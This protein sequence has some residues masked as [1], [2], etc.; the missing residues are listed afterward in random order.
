MNFFHGQAPVTSTYLFAAGLTL[1]SGLLFVS[2]HGIIRHIGGVG[3]TLHPLEIA[4]F[5]NL[6]SA[7]FYLPLFF[8]RG[9]Q[10]L[11]TERLPLHIVR[12][13]FNAT[14]ITAWYTALTLTPLA[15][16][17]ALGLSAPLFVTLGAF[18]FLGEIFRTRRWIAILVGIAGAL[19]II[20]P[21]FEAVS[22]GFLFAILSTIFAAGTKIFAK[23]L[24][25]TDSAI[26]CSAYVAILQTPITFVLALFVWRLPTMEQ[27]LW[28][29]AVGIL[30]AMAHLAMVQA[31]KYV[32]VSSME[33][34]VFMRLVWAAG[35]GYVAFQEFPGPWTWAGAAVIVAASSYIA[36]RE[37][38]AHSQTVPPHN[39][40]AR[41]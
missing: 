17:I 29:A 23:Q 28:M 37:A 6:F 14:A 21:G 19:I 16:V 33:P 35:I 13:L 11:K 34:F 24:I 18:F 40:S 27:L 41:G 38:I 15:D 12:S 20:R 31:Y 30:A 1:L 32:E 3:G 36:R 5:S 26:T 22:T 9:V 25:Q 7:L 10:I 8:R 39:P 2:S 4:F